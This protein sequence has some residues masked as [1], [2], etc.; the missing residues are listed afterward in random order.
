M[1]LVSE[2]RAK[3]EVA[4]VC[5]QD[6]GRAVCGA[7]CMGQLPASCYAGQCWS[8]LCVYHDVVL[9]QVPEAL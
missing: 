3:Q 8:V 9:E 2:G 7:A 6:Q 5:K 4:R 1:M